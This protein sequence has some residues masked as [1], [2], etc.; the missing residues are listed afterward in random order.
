MEEHALLPVVNSGMFAGDAEVP[1]M[2]KWNV[3]ERNQDLI[4]R[5]KYLHYNGWDMG[6][7]LTPGVVNWSLTAS[8]LLLAPSLPVEHP[9]SKTISQKPNLFKIVTPINVPSLHYFLRKH[10]NRMFCESICNGLVNGFWPW[11]DVDSPG[12]SITHDESRLSL[13]DKEKLDFVQKQQDIEI[14]KGHFSESFGTSLLPGMFSAPTFA[15]PEEGSSKLRL[16]MDQSAG[17]Y[18]VNKMCSQHEH[19]FPLDNMTHLGEQILKSHNK[20]AP[21]K[22]LVV[23]KSDVVEVYCLIPMHPI[24]QI[25]QI[26][27]IDGQRYV[28]CNNIF[29]GRQSGD[30]FITVMAAIM[31]IMENVWKV[32]KPNAFVDNVFGVEKSTALITRLFPRAKHKL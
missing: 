5:P 2:D 30:I 15:V 29:G 12:Y 18:S 10:P 31:W 17:S 23:Y 22:H 28:D 24:W 3:L 16:V 11:A 14:Q 6:G 1:C 9:V 7:K 4:Q 8:P 32:H 19:V 13:G 25:K 20:L 27:T 21:G 26:N